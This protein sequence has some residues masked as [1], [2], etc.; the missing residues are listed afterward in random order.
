ADRVLRQRLVENLRRTSAQC[1]ATDENPAAIFAGKVHTVFA[2]SHANH[3]RAVRA[4][5]A[6]GIRVSDAE[7]G[8]AVIRPVALSR[9]RGSRFDFDWAA[10]IHVERPLCNVV[11]MSAPIG[12]FAARIFIPP[13]ELI[14]TP[15]WDEIDHWRGTK[16]HVPI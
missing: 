12:H 16:P 3:A 14:M 9:G 11:V 4:I 15:F 10:V 5:S 2:V 1:A 7:S 13:A 8:M 6:V